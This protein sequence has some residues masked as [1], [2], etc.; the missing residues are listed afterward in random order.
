MKYLNVKNVVAKE[1]GYVIAPILDLNITQKQI[2]ARGAMKGMLR[3]RD[4]GILEKAIRMM[5]SNRQVMKLRKKLSVSGKTTDGKTVLSGCMAF[6]HQIGI[7]LDLV[8][9]YLNSQDIVID[10]VDYYKSC[11][12][13]GEKKRTI[14]SKIENAVLD[15]FGKEYKDNIMPKFKPL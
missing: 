15:V 12:D 11:I 14:L 1:K 4:I 7:P 6:T 2:S 3:L 13:G 8:I 5:V 10:W 9:D